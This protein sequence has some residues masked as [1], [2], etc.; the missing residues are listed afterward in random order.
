MSQ[1]YTKQDSDTVQI[2]K[3][4]VWVQTREQLEEENITF[5]TKIDFLQA[6]IDENNKALA[7]L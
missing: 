6:R 4:T 2:T 7:V 5:Q 3:E 1:T